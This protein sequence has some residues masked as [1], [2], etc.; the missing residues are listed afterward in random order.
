MVDAG[1]FILFSAW[2][3]IWGA[4]IM[5]LA[6]DK[7][8]PMDGANTA[9]SNH[10]TTHVMICDVDIAR[11]RCFVDRT[12]QSHFVW[13]VEE[14]KSLPWRDILHSG[15]IQYWAGRYI[16]ARKWPSWH[17]LKYPSSSRRNWTRPWYQLKITVQGLCRYC[18]TVWMTAD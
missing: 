17:I 6:L 12:S 16:S 14:E 13:W 3:T 18:I 5:W 8:V 1:S 10:E 9:G 15:T 11:R 7:P 2:G 4:K